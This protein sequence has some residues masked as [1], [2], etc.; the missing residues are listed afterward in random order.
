M[1][2][3]ALLIDMA[4]TV[5][6]QA[7]VVFSSDQVSP[8]NPVQS[9]TALDI[10]VMNDDGS[11]QVRLTSGYD[12]SGGGCSNAWWPRISPNRARIAY[13]A[14]ICGDEGQ[15]SGNSVYGADS[16]HEMNDNGTGNTTIVANADVLYSSPT[17][18]PDGTKLAYL[19]NNQNKSGGNDIDIVSS[20][21][22]HPQTAVRNVLCSSIAWAHDNASVYCSVDTSCAQCQQV[23]TYL[24]NLGTG[25]Q[26]P[27]ASL[28]STGNVFSYSKELGGYLFGLRDDN[29]TLIR[30]PVDNGGTLGT[31]TTLVPTGMGRVFSVSPTSTGK[32]YVTGAYADPN[33]SGAAYWWDS[34]TGF[35]ISFAISQCAVATDSG[36]DIYSIDLASGA[37]NRVTT[38]GSP[39]NPGET[40]VTN[41]EADWVAGRPMPLV[42][43]KL[44]RLAIKALSSTGSPAGKSIRTV[45]EYLPASCGN[46]IHTAGGY[47]NA[48]LEYRV[49]NPT[50]GAQITLL[51]NSRKYRVLNF[52]HVAEGVNLVPMENLLVWR[53]ASSNVTRSSRPGIYALR[54]VTSNGSGERANTQNMRFGLRT[55]P[56]ACGG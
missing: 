22:A 15:D 50:Q 12:S 40:A 54:L 20:A 42:R 26:T 34:C 36:G 44:S 17:W 3:C 23:T 4:S 25:T 41:Q 56:A 27:V 8:G 43:P 28:D 31:A 29:A 51:K 24:I 33:A 16:V 13:L 2:V 5:P 6:A 45:T 47:T 30:A 46:G 38:N 21:G 32:A 11:G 9:S 48:V 37:A 19:A 10:W 14:G 18:S 49:T 39:S 35:P 7:Q 53:G 52:A 55:A 1:I